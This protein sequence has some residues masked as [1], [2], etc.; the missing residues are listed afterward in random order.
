MSCL[1]LPFSKCCHER[2]VRF[3]PTRTARVPRC[4]RLVDRMRDAYCAAPHSCRLHVNAVFQ[5]GL[6]SSPLRPLRADE[7]AKGE[8]D[9]LDNALRWLRALPFTSAPAYGSSKIDAEKLP[10]IHLT[11]SYIPDAEEHDDLAMTWREVTRA[12]SCSSGL[13]GMRATL[14]PCISS[15]APCWPS[16]IRAHDLAPDMPPNGPSPARDA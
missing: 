2:L 15:R 7:V 5:Q 3:H 13:R 11:A 16:A 14:A 12:Q 4:Q 6:R 8:A 1:A 10:P 9:A